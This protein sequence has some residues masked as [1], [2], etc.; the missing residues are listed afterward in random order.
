M[1]DVDSGWN[2]DGA[3]VSYMCCILYYIA[4][5]YERLTGSLVLLCN[6]YLH[7]NLCAWVR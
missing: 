7:S 6:L 4:S 1:A 2:M 3:D 5:C